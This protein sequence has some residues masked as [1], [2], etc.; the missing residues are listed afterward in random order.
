MRAVYRG[1]SL[2]VVVGLFTGCG[3]PSATASLPATSASSTPSVGTP[4]TSVP[5]STTA[6]TPGTTGTP[7]R[8]RKL[9]FPPG[10]S[11]FGRALRASGVIARLREE[12]SLTVFAPADEAFKKLPEGEWQAILDDPQRLTQVIEYHI[13][14]GKWT[15]GN[16]PQVSS[17]TTLQGGTLTVHE[18]EGKRFAINGAF[19]LVP[20]FQT[21]RLIVH[22][23][24][25]VLM[26]P[27]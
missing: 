22:T 12:Q 9:E 8:E 6:A 7:R 27:P 13:V 15:T 23:I 4:A 25:T 21:W 5:E 24:D 10:L 3:S 18:E 2:L 26:P 17:L 14:E 20:D 1:L 19:I 16:L 11:T